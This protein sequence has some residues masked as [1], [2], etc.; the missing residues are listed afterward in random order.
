MFD[1]LQNVHDGAGDFDKKFFISNVK[2]DAILNFEHV[3]NCNRQDTI[4]YRLQ[5]GIIGS[6]C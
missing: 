6:S 3:E 5:H 4:I 1:V 2:S